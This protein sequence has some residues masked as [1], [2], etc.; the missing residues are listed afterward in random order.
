MQVW[1]RRYSIGVAMYRG[2]AL[3]ERVQERCRER[4]REYDKDTEGGRERK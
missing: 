3:R 4:V 2:E 1:N